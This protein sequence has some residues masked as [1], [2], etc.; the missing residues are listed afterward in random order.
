MKASNITILFIVIVSIVLI[1]AIPI[2]LKYKLDNKLYTQLNLSENYT[3]DRHN[4][5]ITNKLL[6]SDLDNCTIIPSDSFYI[7]LE[8]LGC[9]NVVITDKAD[10]FSIGSTNR[11]EVAS[12]RVRI[13][14][15][16]AGKIICRNSNV[17]LRGSIKRFGIPS[18]LF[19]LENSK[20]S[21]SA[22]SD[23]W[24]VYQFLSQLEIN[25]SDSAEVNLS[26]SVRINNLTLNDVGSVSTG[27][28]VGIDNMRVS[29]EGKHSV[30]S[31]SSSGSLSIEA[32]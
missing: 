12:Q 19:D 30:K 32:H 8:Q 17:L 13:F 6:I 24:K 23:E 21:T 16:G 4:F 3:Y 7:E 27:N 2:T 28:R 11:G 5:T 26:G 18:F 10:T 14:M 22:I 29:Y 31:N 9:D 20:L 25:G 15:P 1:G